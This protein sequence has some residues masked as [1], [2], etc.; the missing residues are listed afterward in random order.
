MADSD[1]K[2]FSRSGHPAARG[3]AKTSGAQQVA[4][5]S[6]ASG[7]GH[8]APAQAPLRGQM[9]QRYW[10]VDEDHKRK[11]S[12]LPTNV[13]REHPNYA[14]ME[15]PE[16]EFR[17]FPK[18]LYPSNADDPFTPVYTKGVPCEGIIV[19]DEEEQMAVLATLAPPVREAD[20]RKRLIALAE[21][22][23]VT[24]DKRW[25]LAK[26]TAAIEG[27]GFDPTANPFE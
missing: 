21:V 1:P 12:D 6:H 4:R 5:V 17:E 18:M 9:A 19:N 14:R 24:I 7:G 27:A 3:G 2:T 25:S 8:H 15:F 13:P 11:G 23:G 26:I 20:E 22:D 16:Y 10:A